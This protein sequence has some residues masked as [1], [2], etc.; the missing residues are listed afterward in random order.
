MPV[1]YARRYVWPFL[2]YLP[3]SYNSVCH[4][5]IFKVHGGE[6]KVEAKEGIGSEFLIIFS[7][8]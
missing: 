1:N 5:Y 4:L 6:I 8:K 7:N 3:L 2:Y